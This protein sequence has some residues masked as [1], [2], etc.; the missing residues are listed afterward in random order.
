MSNTKGPMKEKAI[1]YTRVSTKE[2]THNTSLGF[3]EKKCYDYAKKMGYEIVQV[4]PEDKGGS[5]RNGERS[6]FMQAV[7]YAKKNEDVKH[8]IVFKF[9][10][11]Y[12]NTKGHL[13]LYDELL[14]NYGV[15]V[16]SATQDCNKDTAE[17]KHRRITY[18]NDAE[19]MSNALSETVIDG[20]HEAKLKGILTSQPP[21]GL[22]KEW[23]GKNESRIIRDPDKA[24]FIEVMFEMYD[25]GKL[26][27][28]II[29]NVNANGFTTKHDHPLNQQGLMRIL[30]N[31]TYT[32]YVTVDDETEMVR[33]NFPTIISLEL[34]HRVQDRL[35]S[36]KTKAKAIYKVNREEFPLRKTLI[37][38]HCGVPLTA[39]FS[40]GKCGKKYGYYC[41]RTKGC[42]AKGIRIGKLHKRFQTAL[43][44]MKVND[45]LFGFL[46]D[47]LQ[48]YFDEKMQVRKAALSKSKIELRHLNDRRQILID[49]FL[50]EEAISKKIYD[51]QLELL[52]S[53]IEQS[54]YRIKTAKKQIAAINSDIDR[55]V[56]IFSD[57]E[58]FWNY[59]PL[60]LKQALQN[61]LFPDGIQFD[62]MESMV[63]P[64]ALSAGIEYG[65]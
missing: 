8:L 44:L 30:R 47:C 34:F 36:R 16:E 46:H 63:D 3:Q 10:R 42:H 22:K 53:Q 51:N 64:D 4:F 48:V 58:Q 35:N 65:A 31:I 11:Y 60:P 12:R 54:E 49:K 24:Q 50:Y 20:M 29:E 15:R 33:G 13:V 5:G 18:A 21:V 55:Y 43:R 14:E 56:D 9:H 57:L 52:N 61:A 2:Q 39:S 6:S 23:I 19:F 45:D 17:D 38:K 59:S 26:V 37:C 32:G 41:C 27:S 62:S 25:D 28:D 7:E 40:T 1:V